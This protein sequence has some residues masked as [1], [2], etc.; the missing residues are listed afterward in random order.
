MSILKVDTITDQSGKGKPNF[1]HGVNV[2]GAVTG[3]SGGDV[4][5][6]GNLTVSG[7]VGV[8]GTLTYEDVTDCLLYT[9][10]SP[11]DVP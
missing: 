5:T 9:S 2:T 3:T 11:R 10:P 4:N 7:N 8:G 1:P 6:V